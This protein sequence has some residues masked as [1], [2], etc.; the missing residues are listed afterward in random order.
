MTVMMTAEAGNFKN[1]VKKLKETE[2]GMRD[3]REAA[4]T[5]HL[6]RAEATVRQAPE[7]AEAAV[8]PVEAA[9]RGDFNLYLFNKHHK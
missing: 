8:P 1:A 3:T 2:K 4:V 7:E 5:D 9:L 6:V